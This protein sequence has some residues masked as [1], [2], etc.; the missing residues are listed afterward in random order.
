[1]DEWP[2]KQYV[3]KRV[4]GSVQRSLHCRAGISVS[5]RGQVEFSLSDLVD[6]L[7]LVIDLSIRTR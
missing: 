7:T 1:M 5:A 6:A 3:R 4:R 2:E